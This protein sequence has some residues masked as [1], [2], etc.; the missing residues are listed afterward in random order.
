VLTALDDAV[1]RVLAA[2]D[3]LKQRERTLVFF[4]SDNGAFM[5]PGRGLEV[6]SNQPLRAGGVTVYEGGVRVPALVRWPGRLRP[7]SVCREMVSSLD[8]LP[9]VLAA[10]GGELPPDRVLDGRN[11]LPTLAGQAPSPHD[12]LYWVWNQ[13]RNEQWRGDAGRQLENRT[14]RRHGAL[15]AL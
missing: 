10:A 15:A 6:Q 8:V 12:A 2:V 14:P 4:I 3:D 1:G 7:G 13:G 9:T 5:L 11:V